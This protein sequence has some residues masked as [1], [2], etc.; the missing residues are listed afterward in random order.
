VSVFGEPSAKDPWGWWFE[1]HHISLNYTIVDGRIISPT[2][3]FFGSNPADVEIGCAALLRPLASVEDLAR[4]LVHML[5]EEQRL[6]AVISPTAPADI[7]SGN[8]PMVFGRDL[9]LPQEYSEALRLTS[10][11]KGLPASA[12]DAAQREILT[13]LIREYV[14]RMP[15]E[16]TEIERK[17]LQRRGVRGVH[18]AWAGGLERRQRHYYRL[19]ALQFLVE[20]DNTQNNANHIHSV[21]RTPSTTSGPACLH[22]TTLALTMVEALWQRR[23]G[24]R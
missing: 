21:W 24:V 8:R 11:P 20:Y 18:L 15:D 9:P 5:S 23:T 6:S 7:V 2:P 16:I 14:G 4:E 22:G 12:M 13:A 19:R 17:R 10:A 3:T 1:G